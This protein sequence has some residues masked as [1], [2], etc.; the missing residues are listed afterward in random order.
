MTFRI[1]D[2]VKIIRPY[3]DFG[4]GVDSLKRF[5]APAYEL[6]DYIVEELSPP[7]YT[8][9]WVRVL[10]W[11]VGAKCFELVEPKVTI[12]WSALNKE[13]SS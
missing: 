4:N 6:N 8:P 5:D 12:N 13:F 9:T 1:G 7:G 10:G 11:Y 3:D 2:K